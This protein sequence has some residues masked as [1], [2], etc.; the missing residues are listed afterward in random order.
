MK[1][2]TCIEEQLYEYLCKNHRG[3]KHMIK[4]WQLRQLFG[5]ASDPHLRKIIQNIRQSKDYP[6]LIGSVAGPEGGYFICETPEEKR[7]TINHIRHRAN[8]ML[9]MCHIMEWKFN[10]TA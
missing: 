9:R 2:E 5:I 7:E 3:R 1:A 8:Q 10:L 4:N 6:L